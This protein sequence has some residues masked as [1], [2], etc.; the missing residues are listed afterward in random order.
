MAEAKKPAWPKTPD[1]T[2]DWEIVFEDQ[3]SGI[4][5]LIMASNSPAGLYKSAEVVIRQI[6][7]RK[8]DSEQVVKFL[9]ILNGIIA[10]QKSD[11]SFESVKMEVVNL[12]RRLKSGRIKRANAFLEKKRLEKTEGEERQKPERRE[13]GGLTIRQISD[14]LFGNKMRI[15]MTVGSIALLLI[16]FVSML[17]VL[18]VVEITSTE[19]D[20]PIPETILES[21]LEPDEEESEEVPEEEPELEVIREYLVIMKPITWYFN[22][23]G[24]K[25]K[26]SF[27]LPVIGLHD[28]DDWRTVCAQSPRIMDAVNLALA[29]KIPKDRKATTTDMANATTYAVAE[30]NKRLGAVLFNKFILMQNPDASMIAKGAR[31]RL[32]EQ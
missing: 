23:G 17:T 12:L 28:E 18:G 32:T 20:E 10:G 13:K 31:C 26:R 29:L 2:I 19:G 25:T 3:T 5:P 15:L 22:V 4:I 27:V 6:F 14:T 11:S 30:I 21:P 9:A 1:G 16:A 7:T 24:T 8:N